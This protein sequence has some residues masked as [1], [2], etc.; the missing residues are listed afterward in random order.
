MFESPFSRRS[1]R[2][3]LPVSILPFTAALFVLVALAAVAA[4]P[5]ES[6]R[7]IVSTDLATDV[8]DA[9][10]LGFLFEAAD[11][12]KG[13]IVACVSD[14]PTPHGAPALRAFLNVWGFDAVPVGAYQGEQGNPT[15]HGYPGAVAREFGQQGLTRKDFPDAVTVL[16]RALAESPDQSVVFIAIGFL[17]ALDELLQSQSDEISPLTGRELFAQKTRLTVAV[18]ANFVG[19]EAGQLRWNWKHAPEAT[20]SV[21]NSM[22]RPFY[23][24]PANEIDQASF[25]RAHSRRGNPPTVTGPEGFGWER[26]N[27]PIQ[28]AFEVCQAEEPGAL[29]AGLHRKAFDPAAVRFATDLD[30]TL[31]QYHH[32]DVHLSV[33]G[34]AIRVDTSRRGVFSILNLALPSENGESGNYLD[35]ILRRLPEPTW[36]R[37][38]E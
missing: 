34:G 25:P 1:L 14:A 31:F 9:A 2:S 20:A 10:A 33:E 29:T 19:N 21:L 6:P 24:L 18:G 17:T 13:E 22:T 3:R 12:G 36:M 38:D 5:A 15:E 16:R 4:E 7:W 8:D 30:E 35:E 11:R 28:L 32:R 37:E 27:H 26:G 23:W